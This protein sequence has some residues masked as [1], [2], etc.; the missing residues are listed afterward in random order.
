MSQLREGRNL[1]TINGVR[2]QIRPV[3]RFLKTLGLGLVSLLLI[4]F[5]L[6]VVK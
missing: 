2:Y 3:D 4:M 6:V 1:V 5:L